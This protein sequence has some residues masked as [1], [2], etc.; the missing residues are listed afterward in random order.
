MGAS[1]AE[2]GIM[3]LLTGEAKPALGTSL[4]FL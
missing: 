4:T 2:K 3:A 1:F